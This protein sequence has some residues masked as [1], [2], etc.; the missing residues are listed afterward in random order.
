[1]KNLRTLIFI[2]GFSTLSSVCYSTFAADITAGRS[3]ATVCSACHG[4]NGISQI[5]TYP[6][7]AGQKEQ[8]LVLQLKAFRNGVRKNMIMT[9]MVADLSDTD[10]DNLSAYFASLDPSGE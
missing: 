4:I 7:L 2:L 5:P 3:K 1:M 8:Y 9:P 10:I 6:N